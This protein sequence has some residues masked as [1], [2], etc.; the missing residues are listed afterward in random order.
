M[1][2]LLA[3]CAATLAVALIPGCASAP[4][5]RFYTLDMTSSGGAAST[6]NIQVDRFR[7]AEPVARSEIM[8]AT[9]PTEI[10]Y[11]AA[12]TWVAN[13]GTLVA[14]KLQAEFGSPDPARETVILSGEILRFGQV[15]TAAGADAHVRI[16]V[17][18]ASP[19]SRRT[20]PP[21]LEKTYEVRA[22]AAS[23]AAPDVVQ[24][25][26]VAVETVAAQIASDLAKT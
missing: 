7:A 10:E 23:S 8:I 16:A 13:V 3:A 12:D 2:A 17:T 18:A 21:Q 26:S 9:S 25:L 15:D 1:K 20:D 19:G 11:Y 24:A 4:A 14:E 5:P 6:V 22:P